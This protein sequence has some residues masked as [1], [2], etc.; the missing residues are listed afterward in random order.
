MVQN[1]MNSYMFAGPA[2][3]VDPWHAESE[4]SAPWPRQIEVSECLNIR[5]EEGVIRSRA[6]RQLMQTKARK[7][8][9][10]SFI[11]KN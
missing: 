7:L 2:A 9:R 3:I 11:S 1:E 4:S 10:I 6:G 5:F 8:K